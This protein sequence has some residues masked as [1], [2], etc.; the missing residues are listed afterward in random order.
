MCE[1][2]KLTRTVDVVTTGLKGTETNGSLKVNDGGGVLALLSLGNGAL[3][4]SEVTET[5]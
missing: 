4:G 3:N 2:M 5:I 1:L